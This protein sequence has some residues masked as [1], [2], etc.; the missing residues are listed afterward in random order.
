M[1][2]RESGRSRQ[3]RHGF[4]LLEVLVSLVILVTAGATVVSL[5]AETGQAV[6]RARDAETELR[7]AVA[8]FAAVT[9]WPRDD[10]DRH[11][12]THPQGPWRLRVDRVAT[13]LYTLTRTDSLGSRPLL[14]TVVFRPEPRR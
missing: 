9:L 13:T 3:E 8:F 7:P 6:R 2:A 5:A 4:A 11:L 14:R 12:G 10:L 1:R